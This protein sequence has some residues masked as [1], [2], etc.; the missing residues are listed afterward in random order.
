M[1][2]QN[3]WI[4]HLGSYRKKHPGQSLKQAMRGAKSS[5]KK[6]SKTAAP[7]A[8]RKGRKKKVQ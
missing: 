4:L 6:V 2:K 7:K 5:Y 3:P 1:T 8:K